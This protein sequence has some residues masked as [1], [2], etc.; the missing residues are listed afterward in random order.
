[1]TIEKKVSR[2]MAILKENGYKYTER[3]K[4]IIELLVKED[5]YLNAKYISE[6]LVKTYPGLSFD[7]IYR[8]LN[9]YVELKILGYIEIKGERFFK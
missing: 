4:A 8:N 9:T 2:I 5:R 3:R 6:I 1:M 7:T